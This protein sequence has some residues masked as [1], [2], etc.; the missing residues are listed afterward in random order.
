MARCGPASAAGNPVAV[1]QM[2]P[3]EMV[4]DLGSG[5][6]IDVL[7]SARHVAPS[8]RAY[9]L[10]GSPDMIALVPDDGYRLLLGES[11]ADGERLIEPGCAQR[12]ADLRHQ[13]GLQLPQMRPRR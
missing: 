6:G 1:A 7:L 10:D 5:S 9:G 12:V 11:G 2:H 3:G 8:G 13:L 4:L